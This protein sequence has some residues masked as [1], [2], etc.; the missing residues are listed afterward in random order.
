MPEKQGKRRAANPD[1]SR[2]GQRGKPSMAEPI[3]APPPEPYIG[4]P[5]NIRRTSSGKIGVFVKD[6]GPHHKGEPWAS[7]PLFSARTALDMKEILV[8]LLKQCEPLEAPPT[9]ASAAGDGLA[10]GRGDGTATPVEEQSPTVS[11]EKEAS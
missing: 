3:A 9:P 7:F 4:A 11:K 5:Y 6:D 10:G 8:H 1:P 2:S